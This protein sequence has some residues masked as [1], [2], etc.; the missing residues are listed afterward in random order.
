MNLIPAIEYHPPP[1]YIQHA[2]LQYE[3]AHPPA[4]RLDAGLKLAPAVH[5]PPKTTTAATDQ[6]YHQPSIRCTGPETLVNHLRW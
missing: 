6:Y 2:I 5:S 1:A 4:I 3:H